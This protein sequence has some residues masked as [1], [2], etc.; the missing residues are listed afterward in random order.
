MANL[1]R[2]LIQLVVVPISC[3]ALGYCAFLWWRHARPAWAALF[4][5]G[6][7]AL[8]ARRVSSLLAL[9]NSPGTMELADAVLIPGTIILSLLLGLMDLDRWLTK[10]K[11]PE[12]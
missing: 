6:I 2:V 3:V 5:F 7:L 10:R 1:I 9:G 8:L 11:S 4:G 12:K